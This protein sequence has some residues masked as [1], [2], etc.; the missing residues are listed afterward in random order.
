VLDVIT[1]IRTFAE[2]AGS[3]VNGFQFFYSI[4]H[5]TLAEW[6][7]GIGYIDASGLLVRHRVFRSSNANAEVN[8]SAGDKDVM[9]TDQGNVQDV[10]FGG[11]V[12]ALIPERWQL[13]NNLTAT[14]SSAAMTQNRLY[15]IP[16][17][18][19]NR[20]RVQEWAMNISTAG[21][22]GTKIRA[23]L[24]ERLTRQTFKVVVD[25]GEI[26]ADGA[27]GV[28]VFPGGAVHLPAGNYFMLI[29]SDGTPSVSMRSVLYADLGSKFFTPIQW[30]NGTLAWSGGWPNPVTG[31][32]AS[33]N[34]SSAP[35]VMYRTEDDYE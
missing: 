17:L 19:I 2:V 14:I 21:G 13:P 16:Y 23:A 1:G 28:K 34:N 30:L 32:N 25:L 9:C 35:T 7:D 11:A 29:V 10:F 4:I 6:E 3:G 15:C 22:A 26:P 24:A 27:A 20:I 12:S 5:R 18:F 33:T 8:F 31:I